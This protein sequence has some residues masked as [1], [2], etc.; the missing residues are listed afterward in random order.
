MVVEGNTNLHAVWDNLLG[1]TQGEITSTRWL[2]DFGK[3]TRARIN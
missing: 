2:R 1:V 3:N